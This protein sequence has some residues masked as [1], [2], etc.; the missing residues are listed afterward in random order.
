MKNLVSMLVLT[1]IVSAC[2]DQGGTLVDKPEGE[3]KQIAQK[4]APTQSAISPHQSGNQPMGGMGVQPPAT[5][6]KVNIEGTSVTVGRLAFQIHPNWLAE[7]P[8]SAM[9]A[10]Q[11]QLPPAEGSE[12]GSL[13]V[14]VG[15]GGSAEANIQRWIGQMAQPDGS[16]PAEKANVKTYGM[17]N[18]EI[19]SFAVMTLDL[20]GSYQVSMMMGGGQTISNA[21]MLAAAIDGPGGPY[22]IKAIGP[23]DTMAKWKPAFDALIESIQ[24]V[25]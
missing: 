9:R 22:H 7:Q 2:S 21:R 13:V 1:L 8:N 14:Y 15:I 3:S 25:D 23:A 6:A 5:S 20:V 16:D 24:K 19:D 12:P 11:F 4:P 18:E 10:A 17:K